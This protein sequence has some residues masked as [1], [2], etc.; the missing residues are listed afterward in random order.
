MNNDTNKKD[1]VLI[2]KFVLGAIGVGILLV[3]IH[4]LFNKN[5]FLLPI[6][7]SLGCLIFGGLLGF[8]YGMPRILFA[9]EKAA[10]AQTPNAAAPGQPVL[11]RS[12]YQVSS[13]LDRI[14]EWLTTLIV[15]LTLVQWEK[16]VAGFNSISGFI[17]YGIYPQDQSLNQPFVASIMFYFPVIGFIGAYL[18]TRT[19]LSRVFEE[20][21]VG[22]LKLDA[23]VRLELNKSDLTN[24]QN[25]TLN[26][27]LKNAANKILDYRLDQISSLEDIIAWS[28]AQLAASNY[29]NAVE[30]YKKAVA[31]APS[32]IQLRLEYLNALYYAGTKTTDQ[33]KKKQMRA[34][35]EAQ[36]L[37][38]YG[39]L[40][41]AT[42]PETKMKV[43]R[44]IT[45][46]YLYSDPP[47]GFEN[48][49]KYGEEFINDDDP[50]KISSV[51][52]LVNLAAAYGQRFKWLKEQNAEPEKLHEARKNALNYSTQTL[53][54]DK[55][56]RWLNRLR[57]L[58]QSGVQKDATDNDLE[59]F[60][61]DDEFRQ[62][63]GL[64]TTITLPDIATDAGIISRLLLAECRGPAFADYDEAA[65]KSAMKA[66]RAVVENRKLKPNLFLAAG[67][68]TLQIVTAPPG[69]ASDPQRQFAGF[70][71]GADGKLALTAG[72]Q[73]NID[74]ILARANSGSPGKFAA[75]VNNA[76][77]VAQGAIEDPFAGLTEINGVP[78]KNGA[79]GWRPEGNP[80]SGA[81]FV[82][83]PTTMSGVILK[84]QFYALK[85][86]AF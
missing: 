22:G 60:E 66:M 79:F 55:N 65:A 25:M 32:D 13:H 75:F 31:G 10:N 68:T 20:T 77:A 50:R 9:D 19:Y 52:V 39:L 67:N 49:I 44:A 73:A 59:V 53:E 69:A 42:P 61:R 57:T 15:G 45:F 23:G 16:V 29:E 38:A 58:L 26:P 84:T 12:I 4:Q 40:D 3:S 85:A 81:L 11:R 30:G 43:Y 63:L 47:K 82:K 7:W 36:L 34:E 78:V 18:M 56:E 8:L 54:K 86:G 71:L 2:G 14:L 27:D 33:P 72:V 6:I 41:G 5:G 76:I 64:F 28:K 17:S 37:T 51:G 48:T 21:D 46:F 1:I 74:A 24:P 70:F 83:I 35:S 62:L 80:I